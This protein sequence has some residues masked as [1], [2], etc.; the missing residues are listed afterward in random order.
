MPLGIDI[1]KCPQGSVHAGCGHIQELGSQDSAVTTS[2]RTPVFMRLAD[3][4]RNSAVTRQSTRQSSPKCPRGP[5]Y[6]GC[7]HIEWTRQSFIPFMEGRGTEVSYWMIKI[8]RSKRDIPP[9]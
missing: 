4:L 6:A 3:T 5:V 9:T 7:G 8:Y 2:A 1:E